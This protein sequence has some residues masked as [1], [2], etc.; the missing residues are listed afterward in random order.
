MCFIYKWWEDV[1]VERRSKRKEI[2]KQF[3]SISASL[4]FLKSIQRQRILVSD[5]E[6]SVLHHLGRVCLFPMLT[7]INTHES[8]FRTHSWLLKKCTAYLTSKRKSR[9]SLHLAP[10]LQGAHPSQMNHIRAKDPGRDP[11]LQICSLVGLIYLENKR[12]EN[13]VIP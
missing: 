13:I 9:C 7:H 11:L 5:K 8:S 6:S 10:A 12:F 3:V 2:R 4:V 1:T